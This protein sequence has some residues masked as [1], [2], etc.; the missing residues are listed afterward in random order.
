M[1]YSQATK[2]INDDINNICLVLANEN[3]YDLTETISNINISSNY[4]LTLSNTMTSNIQYNVKIGDNFIDLWAQAENDTYIASKIITYGKN[5]YTS[6]VLLYMGLKYNT[7]LKLNDIKISYESNYIKTDV[8]LIDF[9]LEIDS[10][11]ITLPTNENE[12]DINTIYLKSNGD[13][14]YNIPTN[15][16]G[17]QFKVGGNG[18]SDTINAVQG[19]NIITFNTLSI[20]TYANITITVTDVAGNVSLPLSIPSFEIVTPPL[21]TVVPVLSIVSPVPTPTNNPT[22][23][24]TFSSSEDGVINYS[25][26]CSSTTTNAVQGNNT[27]IF[28]SLIDGTYSNCTITVTDVAGNVSYSLAIPTFVINTELVDTSV[29]IL[30]IVTSVPTPTNDSTPSFTFSS[31]EAG[32]ISYGG[33]C[34]STT[35]DAIHGNNTITFDS[36]IDGIYSNCTITVTDTAGNVSS[37]LAIP[38]FEIVTVPVD[39]TLPVLAM[40]TPVPN[41][42]NNPTP[43]FTFSSTEAGT[44]S[45]GG[46][47][48]NSVSGGESAVAGL[49]IQHNNNSVIGFSL[50]ESSINT[51]SGILTTLNLSEPST[52]LENIVFSTSS[53]IP[54][55]VSYYTDNNKITKMNSSNIFLHYKIDH[56]N[57]IKKISWNINYDYLQSTTIQQ[58]FID[59]CK[60]SWVNNILIGMK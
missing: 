20:G 53:G 55:S 28:D 56:H 38:S 21:D 29:P 42:T 45:Y 18:N 30:T 14:I 34:N 51:D 11:N 58:D 26:S 46:S 6:A 19:N 49:T 16:Y 23:S 17:Y 10:T 35:T 1:K 40:V 7:N 50:N 32:T 9:N 33:S 5:N 12:L 57:C 24:F 25:G 44:I 3:K 31:S 22:P 52:G 39:T 43:S 60:S 13:I 2:L 47:T 54:I 59:A 4:A 8:N 15:I 37:A 27:I 41:Q 48:I 36:L